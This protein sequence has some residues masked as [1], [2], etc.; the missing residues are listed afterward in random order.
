MHTHGH[1]IA[2]RPNLDEDKGGKLIDPTR[3]RGMVGSLMYLSAS[4]PDI[5]F[6]VCMCARY[7]A[8]P[9][10]MHLTAIKRIFR[11][12]K[13]NHSTG[14]CGCHVTRRSTSVQLTLLGHRLVSWSSKKQKST[15]ISI[16]RLNTSPYQDVVLKSSGCVLNSE[17]MDLRFNKNSDVL[18]QSNVLWLYACYSVHHS[19]PSTLISVITLSKKSA[20][21]TTRMRNGE[22]LGN[23]QILRCSIHIVIIDSIT[24]IRDNCSYPLPTGSE[25]IRKFFTRL[26]PQ[27]SENQCLLQ[28][29]KSFT[30]DWKEEHHSKLFKD[31]IRYEL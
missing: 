27:I 26:P 4:R 31:T 14:S 1:S 2:E 12:L 23:L 20:E 28:I 11:Y 16:R 13:G 18:G 22:T 10:E 15:A 29:S 9:T 30:M 17:T 3:F 21:G 5:V 25:V 8:K 24:E 19:R 6:A 7:Q